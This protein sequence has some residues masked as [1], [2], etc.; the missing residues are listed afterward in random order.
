MSD[1]AIEF[2]KEIHYGDE[3][4]I[5]IAVM[6]FNRVGF[7]LVYKLEKNSDQANTLLA[8][9]KTGMVCYDYSLKKVT[10]LPEPARQKLS[11]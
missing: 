3:V 5:S 9:A 1:V 4:C 6:D 8:L 2:K 10:H 7:D 11:A